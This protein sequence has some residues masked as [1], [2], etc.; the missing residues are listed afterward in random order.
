MSKNKESFYFQHDYNSRNDE[1][2]LKLRS[3][4]GEAGYGIFWMILEKLAESSQ[5]RLKISD[6]PM[7][8]YELHVESEWIADVIQSYDLFKIKDGYFWSTRLLSDL[9]ERKEKSKKAILANK[10]RWDKERLEDEKLNPN[11]FHLESIS[12]SKD[13]IGKDRIGKKI[14]EKRK[15]IEEDFDKFWKEYPVKKSKGKAFDVFVRT[16]VPV[17]VIIDAIRNQKEERRKLL[18]QKIFIPEWKHPTTWLN[19]RCWEDEPTQEEDIMKKEL[20]EAVKKRIEKWRIGL[21]QNPSEKIIEKWK[22]EEAEKLLGSTKL[23]DFIK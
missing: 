7:L 16:E 17:S 10:I 11:G 20:P 19:Q 4:K 14:K 2:I 13:R 18:S 12:E 1:K 21:N 8:A 15:N 9:E 6:I 22:K 5:A 23:Q 3:L